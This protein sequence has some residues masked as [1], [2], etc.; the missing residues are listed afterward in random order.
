MSDHNLFGAKGEIIAQEHLKKKGYEIL[1]CNWRFKKAEI[2][3]ICQKDDVLIFVEV[4]TRKSDYFG[5]PEEF[6]SKKKEKLMFL[7]ANEYMEQINHDWEI[8]FDIIS[9]IAP[10]D[11]EVELNHF[12]DAFF[13]R[14]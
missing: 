12:Q 10:R 11:G 3:V 5:K 9:I 14:F 7:A 1:E 6:V 4:K 2:D 13:P 8:R